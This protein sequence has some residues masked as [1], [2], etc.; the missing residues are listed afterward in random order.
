MTDRQLMCAV[1][2]IQLRLE[3]LADELE[4]SE[5]RAVLS[6]SIAT[7]VGGLPD[8]YWKQFRK[9]EPCGR[10]GCDCHLKVMPEAVKLFTCLREDYLASGAATQTITE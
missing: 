9:V 3:K 8:P 1:R 6:G 4:P 5:F 10:P 7:V 2:Q